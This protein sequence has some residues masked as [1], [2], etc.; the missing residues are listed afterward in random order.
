MATVFAKNE[1]LQRYKTSVKDLFQ[2]KL[3][4]FLFC[5]FL[6]ETIISTKDETTKCSHESCNQRKKEREREDP[7]NCF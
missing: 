1:F 4:H 2:H 7:L 3:G 6:M 5:F